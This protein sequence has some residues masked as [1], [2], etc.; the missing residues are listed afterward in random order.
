MSLPG[1]P[2]ERLQARRVHFD[3]LVVATVPALEVDQDLA[4]IVVN[5][6]NLGLPPLVSEVVSGLQSA[7]LQHRSL[8]TPVT[9]QQCTGSY[10]VQYLFK[11]DS[12]LFSVGIG[13]LGWR[14]LIH[15]QDVTDPR[16]VS[17]TS[18]ACCQYQHTST[19]PKQPTV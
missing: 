4:S 17:P 16:R 18:S 5:L 3:P 10:S 9:A 14:F 7:S 8:I 11:F 1:P 6:H 19:Q 15:V 13:F 12:I 2:V